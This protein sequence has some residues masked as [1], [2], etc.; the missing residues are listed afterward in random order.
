MIRCAVVVAL[1][2]WMKCIFNRSGRR[3]CGGKRKK[4]KKKN[5]YYNTKKIKTRENLKESNYVVSA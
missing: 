2:S 4:K 5:K 1:S 3:Q